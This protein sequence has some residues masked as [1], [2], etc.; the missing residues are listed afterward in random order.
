MYVE[1]ESQK[2]ALDA[3]EA[4]RRLKLGRSL[5]KVIYLAAYVNVALT[6]GVWLWNY[7]YIQFFWYSLLI[8]PAVI[9]ARL[10]SVF[11]AKGLAPLWAD[12]F[13]LYLI[14]LLLAIPFFIPEAS[15]ASAVVCATVFVAVG[16]LSGTRLLLIGICLSAFGFVINGLFGKRFE[17]LWF[18]ALD[19]TIS[20]IAYLALGV[21][22]IIATGAIFYSVLNGQEKLYRQAQLANMENQ[23]AK[24][25]AE[26]A[27][28][29]K[30]VFLATMSHELRTPLNAILGFSQLMA[31]DAR[32]NTD[33]RE[34]IETINRSG[35]HLLG[36]INNVLEIAKIESGH[37]A[38]Q[39]RRF[40]LYKLVENIA[41]MFRMQASSKGIDLIVECAPDVPSYIQMD[42]GKLRQILINLLGNA[43]KFTSA[44]GVALRVSRAQAAGRIRFEVEDTGPGMTTEELATLSGPFAQ[45]ATGQQSGE[46]TGLGLHISR[47]FVRLLGGELTIQS[48]PGKGSLF[49]FDV[50]ATGLDD[51]EIRQPA[52]TKPRVIGL[53]PG[54]SVYRL[55]I[56]EDQ[57]DSRQVLFELL[58]GVGFQV[59]AAVNGQ[60]AVSIWQDWQP[61]LIWMDMRM[62][63]MNGREATRKIK[64]LPGGQEAIIIALT[65]SSFVEEREEILADGCNDFIR[66]PYREEEIFDA[67]TRHLGVRFIYQDTITPKISGAPLDLLGLSSEWLSQLE[68]ATLK[69]DAEEIRELARQLR[70]THPQVMQEIIHLVANFAYDVI[71]VAIGQAKEK[72]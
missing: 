62:P 29:A 64:S 71:I 28:R 54:Q 31:R 12:L 6:L 57:A 25:I 26:E 4:E 58:T 9:I 69:A 33:H 65:A 18:P 55:L 72:L 13:S 40:D 59:K 48:Q 21:F 67:L 52:Q 45:T 8:I 37:I 10:Q 30:S 70:D 39:E 24:A 1:S 11:E 32:L 46:G 20:L 16:L 2:R 7:K 22:A 51:T 47:Q 43:V 23:K 68:E 44:G 38:L 50:P 63:L 17:G 56:A 41:A 27:N 15:L 49:S 35:E 3:M 34:H 14:F 66:K 60:E 53:E 42:D 36:L 61:H 5:A 19:E